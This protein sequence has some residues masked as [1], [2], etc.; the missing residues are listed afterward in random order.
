MS[1]DKGTVFGSFIQV[2]TKVAPDLGPTSEDESKAVGVGEAEGK[3]SADALAR[4]YLAQRKVCP[5][6]FLYTH[7]RARAHGMLT[8]I[9]NLHQAEKA[10]LK[11][12][13]SGKVC[14]TP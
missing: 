5:S 14:Q 12:E 4:T 6:R 9:P 10:A 1:N 7:A 8:R 2:Q 11:D 3:D 13:A